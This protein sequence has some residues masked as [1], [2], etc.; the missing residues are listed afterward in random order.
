MLIAHTWMRTMPTYSLAETA[1]RDFGGLA[2]ERTPASP[3]MP[4][5]TPQERLVS[6]RWRGGERS[7]HD[8]RRGLVGAAGGLLPHILSRIQLIGPQA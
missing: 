6:L 1:G 7:N 2:T 3:A 5:H 8:E 4:M